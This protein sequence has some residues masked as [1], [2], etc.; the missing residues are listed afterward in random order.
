MGSDKGKAR[1]QNRRDNYWWNDGTVFL[2]DEDT[3][4]LGS[5]P[6]TEKT[7]KDILGEMPDTE[8]AM[9]DAQDKADEDL[10]DLYG[11]VD[12]ITA[13]ADDIPSFDEWLADNGQ[14]RLSVDS[15]LEGMQGLIDQL[16]AGPSDEDKDAA[17][18]HAARMMGLTSEEAQTILG[19]L[20]KKMAGYEEGMTQEEM[21][22]AGILDNFDG[23]T[24]EEMALRKRENQSNLR[25]A[26]DRARRL[27]Q[28][29]FAD[30][31]STAK[32]LQTAD[33]ATM[34]INNMQLQ[35]DAALA[36]EDFERSFAEFQSLKASQQQMVE[37]NQI[38][39]TQYMEN[40]QQG[41]SLA[42]QGY[43]QKI[44]AIQNENAA[45]RD[46]YRGD[47]QAL[48]L[49]IDTLYK[50]ANLEIGLVQAEIDLVESYYNQEM[51]PWR[52]A[53]EAAL[54]E[55]ELGFDWGAFIGGAAQVAAG[56]VLTVATGGAATPAGVGL[57]A[58]GYG[59]AAQAF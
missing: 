23:M 8:T 16:A 42:L 30:S 28:D 21:M 40:L 15:E 44:T 48:S 18:E 26:E 7:T 13:M 25:M 36:Q 45:L 22:D 55:D 24:E 33:Q 38:G 31:G 49:Q 41:M 32:M 4:L 39:V 1:R 50:A 9:D 43:A 54:I 51:Q 20:T 53:M 2:N 52:D 57:V 29:T 11:Q 37:T 6:N 5:D 58:S 35:Q 3:G 56:V 14:E 19:G 27:V 34:Q 46:E 12:D 10:E 17:F 59:T 47:L